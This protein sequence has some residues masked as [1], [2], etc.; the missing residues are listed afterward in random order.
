MNK[1]LFE[2]VIRNAKNLPKCDFPTDATLRQ[3]CSEMD[4]EQLSAFCKVLISK[5]V[6]EYEAGRIV[7]FKERFVIA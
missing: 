3:I 6:F 2:T 5:G 1:N 7:T 4:S